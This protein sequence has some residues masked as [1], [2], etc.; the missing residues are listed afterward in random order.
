M[1]TL[2]LGVWEKALPTGTE[3]LSN[4]E[5]PPL[6]ARANQGRGLSDVPHL[7]DRLLASSTGLLIPTLQL[8][9]VLLFSLQI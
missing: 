2:P 6:P 3:V 9:N 1:N 4:R 5:A 8:H 7:D